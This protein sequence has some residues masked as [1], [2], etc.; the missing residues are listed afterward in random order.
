MRR[1]RA[2]RRAGLR[3]CGPADVGRCGSTGQRRSGRLCV[4]LPAIPTTRAS[5]KGPRRRRASPPSNPSSD[6]GARLTARAVGHGAVAVRRRLQELAGGTGGT[7]IVTSINAGRR[8]HS[9]QANQSDES[10]LGAH[11]D[12]SY[13]FF[14]VYGARGLAAE[15]APARLHRR[16]TGCGTLPIPAGIKAMQ[17]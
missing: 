6:P 16:D 11:H 1:A 17:C 8:R 2:F 14:H 12:K 13:V 10:Y 5:A 7:S 3:L 15:K 9:G 4:I